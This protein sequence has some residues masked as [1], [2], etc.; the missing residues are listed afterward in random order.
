[1]F[2]LCLVCSSNL[3]ASLFLSV[4]SLQLGWLGTRSSET[5]LCTQYGKQMEG[6]RKTTCMWFSPLIAHSVLQ[7]LCR[8]M[9]LLI[10]PFTGNS[11]CSDAHPK[12]WGPSPGEG[13]WR[14][15]ALFISKIVS[16]LALLFSCFLW[17]TSLAM[18]FESA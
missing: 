13:Q 8:T 16:H 4:L 12:S 6:N 7:Q 3:T 17:H 11:S 14:V 10:L 15:W 9:G 5:Q 1:M 2:F 18:L